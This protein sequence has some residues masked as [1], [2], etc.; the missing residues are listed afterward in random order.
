MEGSHCLSDLEDED[1]H[2][3][4]YRSA[5]IGRE[6]EMD[7]LFDRYR[8][9]AGVTTITGLGGVGKTALLQNF[10]RS[11]RTQRPPMVWS[12]RSTPDEARIEI[13]GRI[14][15]LY[16]DRH[17][18]E[19]IAID[20][21]DGL[22][23]DDLSDVTHRILNFKAVR[24]LIFVARRLPELSRVKHLRLEEL[25]DRDAHQMARRLLGNGISNEEAKEVAEAAGRLPLALTLLARQVRGCGIEEVAQLLR[26]D[27]YKLGR[28]IIVPERR[29]ITEVKPRIVMVN[30]ALVERMRS[31]PQS[32]YDL[33]PR[34]FEELIAEL[35][36]DLGYEVELTPATRDGG[37]DIL[38]YMA[39]PHGRLLCLVE[40]KRYRRDRPVGVELVRQL[41]GTLTDAEASSAMLV[42]TSSF[43]PDARTFQKRHEYRLTLRD[44][45]HIVD[46]M[47]GYR[48]H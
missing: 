5:F 17:V 44:Y 30:E 46:W 7:W 26:G 42:T 27:L 18:P 48:R 43:S 24:M 31:H 6:R 37:K 39:T 35:L 11:V 4:D 28:Q 36:T 25:S 12:P 29:L 22:S 2:S 32:I 3:I 19:I 20:D 8:D 45:G 23:S 14:D 13:I 40:A 10:L 9:R 16:H 15:E 1:N 21:A 38:A 33:P 34:K 47:A 41:Y